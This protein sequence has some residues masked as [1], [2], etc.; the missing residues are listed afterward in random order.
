MAG[1]AEEIMKPDAPV[2]SVSGPAIRVPV[3]PAAPAH[4]F[5]LG[6]FSLPLATKAAVVIAIHVQA[7]T[8]PWREGVAVG[9]GGCPA[10]VR[11][12]QAGGGCP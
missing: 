12:L 3:Y 9:R 7:A 2:G 4:F 5:H 11:L 1:G 6:C 8:R 10:A